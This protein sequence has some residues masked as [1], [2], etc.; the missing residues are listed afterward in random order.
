MCEQQLMT[1]D[2]HSGRAGQAA[3]VPG[4]TSGVPRAHLYRVSGGT[5]LAR[6]VPN[7]LTS[8]VPRAHL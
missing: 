5:S 7:V 6:A 2:V 1:T 4:L 8:G 3:S